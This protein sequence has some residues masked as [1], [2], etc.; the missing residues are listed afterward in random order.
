YVTDMLLAPFKMERLL[1]TSEKDYFGK[2][3][4]TKWPDCTRLI[5]NGAVQICEV[6]T[7]LQCHT[8]VHCSDGWDRTPQ[9]SSLAMLLMDPYYRTL[10]GFAVLVEKEWTSFGHR[11]GT[12]C[13]QTGIYDK[14][15]VPAQVGGNFDS[16]KISPVF[17]QWLDCVFQLITQ[18]P[19]EY[20][21][22]E[23]LLLFLGHHAYSQRFGTFL[24]DCEHDRTV[25]MLPCLTQSV[26]DMALYS[27][28]RVCGTWPCTAMLGIV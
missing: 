1:G 24:C 25:H 16:S 18:Q 13:K 19:Q 3:R 27:N 26:W 12:R 11:F 22:N 6:T 15:G 9:L 5:L 14:K 28:A 21:F 4:D 7:Q 23:D 17:L 20:E 10:D 2:L 8:F